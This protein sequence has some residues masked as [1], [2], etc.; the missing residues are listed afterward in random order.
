MEEEKGVSQE[1][2]RCNERMRNGETQRALGCLLREY[3]VGLVRGLK[4]GW[5]C[6]RSCTGDRR[7]HVGLKCGT[8]RMR[9]ECTETEWH[10]TQDVPDIC[11]FLDGRYFWLKFSPHNSA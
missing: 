10:Y 5:S 4:G 11:H 3:H 7:H 2:R 1:T 9:D 6:T 8:K